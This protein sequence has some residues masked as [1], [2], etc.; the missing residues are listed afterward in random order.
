MSASINIQC[1]PTPTIWVSGGAPVIV[2]V[3][4]AGRVQADEA[5]NI[6]QPDAP[7]TIVPSHS[8]ENQTPLTDESGNL[9]VPEPGPGP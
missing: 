3:D 2:Q 8:D 6:L 5:G 1:R 4:E 7:V 9:N